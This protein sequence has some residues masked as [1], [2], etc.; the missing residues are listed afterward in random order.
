MASYRSKA[1]RETATKGIERHFFDNSPIHKSK[2]SLK[3]IKELG[4]IL[5][6]NPAYSPVIAPSDF[7]L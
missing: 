7:W 3:I 5:L 4:F 6:E 2:E 1:Q